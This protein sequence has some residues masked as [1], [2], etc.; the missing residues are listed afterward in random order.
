MIDLK[1]GSRLRQATGSDVE[2]RPINVYFWGV[3]ADVG[4]ADFDFC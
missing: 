2:I 3:E 1:P 4:G